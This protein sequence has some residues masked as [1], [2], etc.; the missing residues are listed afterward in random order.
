MNQDYRPDNPNKTVSYFEN[1]SFLDLTVTS[2]PPNF[3]LGDFTCLSETPCNNTTLANINVEALVDPKPITCSCVVGKQSNDGK[4]IPP[5]C[6]AGSCPPPPPPSPSPPPPPGPAPAGSSAVVVPCNGSDARQMWIYAESK[7]L[8]STQRAGRTTA[9]SRDR[10]ELC[11]DMHKR[12]PF[13]VSVW[14]CNHVDERVHLLRDDQYW[15]FR[16]TALVMAGITVPGETHP[17]CLEELSSHGGVESNE[18]GQLEARICDSS[19][20]AQQWTP[21]GTEPGLLRNGLGRCVSVL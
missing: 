14:G 13:Q 3:P 15:T 21:V 16:G 9:A 6:T 10:K 19:R 11:L 5:S 18:A 7:Y 20:K 17:R 2:A 4:A 12:S 8:V 1:L